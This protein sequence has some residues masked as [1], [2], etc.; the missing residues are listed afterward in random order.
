MYYREQFGTDPEKV[1]SFVTQLKMY[2]KYRV[3]R[4]THSGGDVDELQELM[5]DEYLKRARAGQ[6]YGGNAVSF[7]NSF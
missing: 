4:V 3:I 2:H 1:I 7:L 5:E 6:I